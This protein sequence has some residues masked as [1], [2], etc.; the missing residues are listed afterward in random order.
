MPTKKSESR[1]AKSKAEP[2]SQEQATS[3]NFVARPRRL[4]AASQT[5]RSGAR[6]SDFPRQNLAATLKVVD[7]GGTVAHAYAANR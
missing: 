7:S 1:A 3:G 5:R 4:S 2:S 6:L